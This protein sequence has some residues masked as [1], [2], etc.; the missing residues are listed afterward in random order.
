VGV[1]FKNIFNKISSS[2]QSF[3]KAVLT[4]ITGSSIAQLVSFAV[5]PLLTRLYA[6]EDFGVFQI[7]SSISGIA[8][9]IATGR[10]EMA[11]ML[12]KER[13]NAINIF[14]LS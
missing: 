6:P 13:Q 2:K 9:V 10:L 8:G 3:T 5:S 4:L 12:P 14:I 11:I 1:N 7:F